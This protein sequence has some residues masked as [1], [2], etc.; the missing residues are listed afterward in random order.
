MASGSD[1]CCGPPA[2]IFEPPSSLVCPITLELFLDSVSNAVGQTYERWAIEELF[3]QWRDGTRIPMENTGE[4]NENRAAMVDAPKHSS[5]GPLDPSTG[6]EL[7]GNTTLIP[8][9]LAR[10][11]ALEYRER[12]AGMCVAKAVQIGCEDPV[13]YLK[14]A[15]ELLKGVDLKVGE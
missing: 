4:S 9:V 1:G 3:N 10:G 14:R 8:A 11:Q 5:E 7:H 6:E 15:A 2:A 12:A 13:K